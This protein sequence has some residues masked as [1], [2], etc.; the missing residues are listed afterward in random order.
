MKVSSSN[1]AP[2]YYRAHSIVSI[3]WQGQNVA[4][5]GLT[6]RATYTVPTGRKSYVAGLFAQI[7]RI[8]AAGTLGRAVGVVSIEMGN[9]F[10]LT[11]YDNTVG[12]VQALSMLCG[13]WLNSGSYVDICT[14][15]VSVGG[16]MDYGVSAQINEVIL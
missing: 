13:L 16:T 11:H 6:T 7:L 12:H 2:Y 14:Y 5:H 10:Y 3:S 8:T 1:K 15:D 4:P 9:D